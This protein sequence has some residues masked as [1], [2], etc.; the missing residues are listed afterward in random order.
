MGLAKQITKSFLKMVKDSGRV[1]KSVDQMKDKVL[2]EGL[3]TLKKA[4]IDPASLP[5]DP[6]ALLKGN[7]ENPQS[8]LTPENICSIP[9][10]TN[11][12]KTKLT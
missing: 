10:L 5:F 6:I 8:I 9:P 7:I 12:Q 1:Q 3:N 4:G 2:N 11:S